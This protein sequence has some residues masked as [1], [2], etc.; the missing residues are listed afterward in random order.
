MIKTIFYILV[1][2][3]LMS[4]G[5]MQLDFIQELYTLFTNSI[6]SEL[7]GAFGA[8]YAKMLTYNMIMLMIAYFMILGVIGLFIR[9]LK[10]K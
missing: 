4:W 7:I 10:G 9:Y 8:M 1:A 5:L 2:V 3:L 6:N